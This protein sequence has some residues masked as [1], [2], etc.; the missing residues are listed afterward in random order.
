M[1]A[2]GR[3]WSDHS[4]SGRAEHHQSQT[5]RESEVVSESSGDIQE[6]GA[7]QVK[8]GGQQVNQRMSEESADALRLAAMISY[9][10][11]TPVSREAAYEAVWSIANSGIISG[12]VAEEV[13]RTAIP[14]SRALNHIQ[15]DGNMRTDDVTVIQMLL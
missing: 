4:S 12:S 1:V 11:T 7:A 9:L 14:G 3:R 15:L 8:I 10:E 5:L 6:P 2:E 13:L